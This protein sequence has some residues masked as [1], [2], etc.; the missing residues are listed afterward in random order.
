MLFSFAQI[1]TISLI[2]NHKYFESLFPDFDS[3]ST[4]ILL[5]QIDRCWEMGY[6]KFMWWSDHVGKVKDRY[7]SD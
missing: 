2:Q 3:L 1:C 6:G 7:A 5:C 4:P